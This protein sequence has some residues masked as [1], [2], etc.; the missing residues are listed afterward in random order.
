MF[1]EDCLLQYLDFLGKITTNLFCN[2]FSCWNNQS[3]RTAYPAYIGT[4]LGIL[5]AIYGAA[6]AFSIVLF[7]IVLGILFWAPGL[8]LQVYFHFKVY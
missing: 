5:A 2:L 3:I 1:S 4:F 7:P 6:G 8:L